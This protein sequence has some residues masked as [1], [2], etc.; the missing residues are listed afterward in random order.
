MRRLRNPILSS[1]LICLILTIAGNKKW[2]GPPLAESAPSA[3]YAASSDRIAG[4]GGELFGHPRALA[5]LFGTEMWERFSYY[6]MRALLVLY[7]TKYVLLPAQAGHVVGLAGFKNGLE[8][9]FGPLDVQPLASQIYGLYTA[10]VY[11]TPIFGGLLADRVLGQRR[12]VIIGAT[13]MAIGHFLMAAESLLLFALFVLILG[14][15]AFKPNI[16]TQVGFLYPPGDHRGDRAYSI[17][18]VGINIGAF[19]APLIC[20]T[21]GEKAGWHYGFAAA[22]VGML[23][24]LSIYLYASPLMPADALQKARAV[25]AERQPLNH[26]ERRGIAA[27]LALFIP[28]ALFWA[29]YEQSGN[30]IALW[31]DANTDRTIDFLGFS[32]EIPTTWFQAFNPFMIFAFTPFIVALWSRQAARG[33]EPS[34]IGK[35]ALGCFGVTLSFLVLA[36]A[37]WHAGG[38]KASWLWLFAFFAIIT[39]GELY[40]SPVGLSLVTKIAPMRVLSMMMGV[41]LATSFVGGFL[42]GWLGGFWTRMGKPEFFLLMAAIAAVAGVAIFAFRFLLRDALPE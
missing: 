12:M 30:T 26:E 39:V 6:G 10:L 42:A 27:I 20:G 22:G 15:G 4:R 1:E 19:L 25:S 33:S 37:A 3:S 9:V 23:I 29:T 35:M 32:A 5:F 13:L 40:L 24:G 8:A 31:A 28:T 17:F 2:Y 34:T 18:Y 11:L 7:M 36:L 41:W 38:D 16:S 21:L 14:N